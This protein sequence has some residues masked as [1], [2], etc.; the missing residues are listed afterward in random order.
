MDIT[1]YYTLSQAAAKLGYA[2]V[3]SL[4]VYCKDGRIP[5]IERIGR[6]WL[7]PKVWVHAELSNPSLVR[8]GGRGK[9][10]K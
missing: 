9:P 2:S 5:G 10:R 7:I 8:Q 6:S 3:S 4:S 1:E